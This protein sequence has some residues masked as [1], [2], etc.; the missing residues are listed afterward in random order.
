VKAAR[1]EVKVIPR[2][3]RNS[4]EI[5]DDKIKVKL[6]TVPEK[7]KANAML[8]D[9]LSKTLKIPKSSFSI[10]KGKSSR[11]KILAVEGFDKSYIIKKLL[12]NL[13]KTRLR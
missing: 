5:E 11:K 3:S 12:E 7:G 9:M 13:D 1:I 8:I 4:I 6:T 10:V 2:S